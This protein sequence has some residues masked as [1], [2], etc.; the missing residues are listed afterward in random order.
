MSRILSIDAWEYRTK[1]SGVLVADLHKAFDH[2]CNPDDW[3]APIDAIVPVAELPLTVQAIGFYT[4]TGVKTNHAEISGCIG[5]F[6][7]VQS[8]G[9]R[10]GPC[11]P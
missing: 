2:V 8:V 10:N 6:W 5:E 1:D 7:R 3:R 11:G 9:Y 4:G